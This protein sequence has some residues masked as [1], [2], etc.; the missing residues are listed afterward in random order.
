MRIRKNLNKFGL[1]INKIRK[2]NNIS[3][4]EMAKEIGYNNLH[5]YSTESINSS[6]DIS[7]TYFRRVLSYLK[8]KKLLTDE[9]SKELIIAFNRSNKFILTKSSILSNAQI[10]ENHNSIYNN[11]DEGEKPTMYNRTGNR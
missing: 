11:V 4:L 5:V 1:V 6:A 3:V 10:L 2:D 7:I 8:T 9:L